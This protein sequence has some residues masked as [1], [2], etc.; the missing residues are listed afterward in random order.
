MP[1]R[2]PPYICATCLSEFS[3][4]GSREAIRCAVC[5]YEWTATALRGLNSQTMICCFCGACQTMPGTWPAECK[6]C[7]MSLF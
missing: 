5:N 3:S 6:R 7:G 4:E 1:Q 2:I